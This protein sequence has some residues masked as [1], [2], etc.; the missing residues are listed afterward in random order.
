M[1]F[2]VPLV[3]KPFVV[4]VQ[5]ESV[6]INTPFPVRLPLSHALT[7]EL[8]HAAILSADRPCRGV[9]GVKFDRFVALRIG[10]TQT[11][12]NSAALVCLVDE[13][14]QKFIFLRL[15]VF[16]R[17][18]ADSDIRIIARVA[19]EPFKPSR[20]VPD[21]DRLD[22]SFPFKPPPDIEHSVE[23][24]DF[25]DVQLEVLLHSVLVDESRVPADVLVPVDALP[26]AKECKRSGIQKK[27]LGIHQERNLPCC[28]RVKALEDEL[29]LRELRREFLEN[30]GRREM[31]FH[32]LNHS[33]QCG[34][35]TSP[36]WFSSAC[37]S[38]AGSASLK[39]LSRSASE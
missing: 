37:S 25:V 29:A 7:V 22:S 1:R 36:S 24:D 30:P 27:T 19:F 16:Y 8:T 17:E 31:D 9:D 21:R 32:G 11:V 4:I 3:L 39:K 23:A 13:V 15:N 35:R 6:L 2:C 26:A 33:P 18:P 20:P 28:D 38:S 10:E 14:R 12:D 34:Q 5:H